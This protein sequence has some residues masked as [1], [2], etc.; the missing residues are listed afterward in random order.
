MSVKDELLAA[1]A[2]IVTAVEELVLDDEEAATLY[3]T[4]RFPLDGAL[5][6]Q[7]RTLLRAGIEDG[8]L[9]DRENAG[10]RFSRLKKAVGDEAAIDLVHMHGPGPGHLHP[11]GEVDLC[12]AVSGQPRFDGRTQGFTVYKPGSWHVPT[13]DGGEMD[14]IY[15]LPGGAITFGPPAA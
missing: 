9:C 15:F 12:F 5:L 3:L 6:V 10:V 2:P 1:L 8:S 7:V 11:R 4:E 14:I 13:V